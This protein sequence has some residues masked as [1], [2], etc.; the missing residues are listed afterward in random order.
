MLPP[1]LSTG[2]VVCC[3][4]IRKL[5]FTYIFKVEEIRKVV[6][7]ELGFVADV[8]NVQSEAKVSSLEIIARNL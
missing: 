7:S 6:D 2:N 4:A 8:P 3:T 5:T 1:F